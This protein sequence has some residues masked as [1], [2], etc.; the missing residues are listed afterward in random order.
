M[1]KEIMKLGAFALLFFGGTFAFNQE[2]GPDKK[3]HESKAAHVFQKADKDKDGFITKEEAKMADTER[4]EKRKEKGKEEPKHGLYKDFDSIDTNKDNKIDEKELTAHFEANK[5]GPEKFI[6]KFDE[7]S[8]GKLDKNEAKKAK[9]ERE[10]KMEEHAEKAKGN[11][12]AA[13][14][15][16]IDTDGNGELS[17]AEIGADLANKP[18]KDH[19]NKKDHPAPTAADIIKKLDSDGN[20]TISKKEAE[21][22]AAKRAAKMEEHKKH[23]IY[24][25]FDE[26]DLNKDGFLTA[27]EL[28]AFHE[29]K[30]KKAEKKKALPR[31]TPNK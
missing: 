25:E 24:D 27:D 14:F 8:D 10:K 3:G 4:A 20:G 11:S 22:H 26:I 7:N 19:P 28:K 21:D 23:N 16:L 2:H 15:D 1:N 31:E 9:E 30:G 17:E 18:K 5:P 6:A 12:I 13:R 29:S